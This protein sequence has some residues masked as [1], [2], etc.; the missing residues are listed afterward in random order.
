[1]ASRRPIVYVSGYLMELP[2]ND[3]VTGAVQPNVSINPS[4]ATMQQNEIAIDSAT[5]NLVVRIGDLVW[6]FQAAS[7]SSYAGKLDFSVARNSHWVGVI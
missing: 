7:A 2:I 6:R 1:M 4:I 5:G 3:G